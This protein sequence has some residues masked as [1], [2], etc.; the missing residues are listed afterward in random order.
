MRVIELGERG[1][2]VYALIG[3]GGRELRILIFK[4]AAEKYNHSRIVKIPELR[5]LQRT[6][7]VRGLDAV[8]RELALLLPKTAVTTYIILIDREHVSNIEQ[9]RRKL[10]EYGFAVQNYEV[11]HEGCWK[12]RVERGTKGAIVYVVIFGFKKCIEEHLVE[13]IHLLYN[14]QIEPEKDAVNRWLRKHRLKDEDLVK[15]ALRRQVFEKTFPQLA[16]ALRELAKS[17]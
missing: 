11:L 8:I 16:I 14:E 5:P 12:V 4:I 6:T 7:G 9:L 10:E 1:A 3:D 13:L 15:E 17:S 2:D